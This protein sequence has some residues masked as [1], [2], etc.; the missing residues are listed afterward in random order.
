MEAIALNLIPS[1]EPIKETA[2]TAPS[3]SPRSETSGKVAAMLS[4]TADV[5]SEAVQQAASELALRLGLKVELGRDE[6][7]GRNI[8]RIFN[9]EGDRLLRQIPAETVLRMLDRLKAGAEESIL[10]LQV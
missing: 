4:S 1:L 2:R 9:Q 10:E 6:S 3:S 8:V 5:S 7:T